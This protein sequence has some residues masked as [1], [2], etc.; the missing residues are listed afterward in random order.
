LRADLG[1]NVVASGEGGTEDVPIVQT[2]LPSFLGSFR[3]EFYLCVLQTDVVILFHTS[4]V[5]LKS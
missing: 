2:W 5:N 4:F 1:V 3:F